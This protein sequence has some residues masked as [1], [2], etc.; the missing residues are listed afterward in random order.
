MSDKE[1]QV[2][3]V[4]P[5]DGAS[6]GL[7]YSPAST[8]ALRTGLVLRHWGKMGLRYQNLIGKLPPFSRRL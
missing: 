3:F 6:H 4:T 7:L 8:S 1:V 5:I 2:A